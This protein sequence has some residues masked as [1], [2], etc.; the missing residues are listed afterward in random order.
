MGAVELVEGG[1]R[2]LDLIVMDEEAHKVVLDCP[3]DDRQ[4]LVRQAVKVGLI[5]CRDAATVAKADFVR[6][7]FSKL[8]NEMEQYWKEQIKGKID[9][10]LQQFFDGQ[11]GVLPQT[12]KSY[13][14]DEGKLA[15]LFDEKDTR[16]LPYQLKQYLGD[17]GKLPELFNEKNTQSITYQLKKLLTDQLTGENSTFVKAVDPN[18]PDSPAAKLATRIEGKIDAVKDLLVGEKR[19][20]EVKEA[21]PA[22]GGD[23]EDLVYPALQQIAKP[24]GDVVEDVHNQNKAGD[25]VIRLDANT[26]P[27]KEIKIAADAKHTRLTIPECERVLVESKANWE[28][29]AALVVFAA[30]DRAPNEQLSPFGQMANGFVCVYDRETADP[31]YLSAAFRLARIQAIREIQRAAG[32]FEPEAVQEKVMQAAAKLRELS[33]LKRKITAVYN[34]TNELW[35]FVDRIQRE[36]FDLLDEARLAL[37]AKAPLPSMEEGGKE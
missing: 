1:V 10:A 33:T 30:P 5:M 19:A 32:L 23:Y 22:K 3:T 37:G 24:F 27:G 16:S 9:E 13:L 35:Q 31:V 25:Y 21:T 20:A 2:I 11:R 8:K 4:Q 28:A 29:S 17:G 15:K 34:A 36:M 18:T 7:E 6:L 14:G 26:I 12:L